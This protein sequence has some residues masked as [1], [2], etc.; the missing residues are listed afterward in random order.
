SK[1]NPITGFGRFFS[2]RSFMELFKGVFKMVVV[3][4]LAFKS[5]ADHQM[6][7]IGLT[8]SDVRGSAGLV[9]AIASELLLKVGLAYLVL[10]IGDYVFQKKQL[11]KELKMTK[12][13]I[14]EEARSSEQA[15]EIRARIRSIQRQLARKRMMQRV[16]F[17][18]VVITNPTHYAVALQYEAAK[19]AA[20]R[21]VAKG[22][23][24]L[25][26]QIKDIARQH[27][28]PLVEN[29]PLAQALYKAVDVDQEVPRELYQA[30][31][32]VL[33][34]IYRLKQKAS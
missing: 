2:I 15:P 24:L 34:F 4:F 1:L 22:Q 14:K 6:E 20:P 28:V 19:M 8:G 11:E 13:E 31:A 9:M 27:G 17:A 30:V 5:I 16:P 26:Q 10:A 32:E 25:A 3:G 33:A 12:Q 7:L 21:V 23:R 29:K 18:D